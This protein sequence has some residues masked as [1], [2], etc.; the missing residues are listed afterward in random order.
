[1]ADIFHTFI[2]KATPGKIFENITTAEGLDKWWTKSSK[3]T[4]EIGALYTLHFGSE[5]NWQAIVT[6]LI[7]DNEFE[8]QITHAYDDWMNTKVGFILKP[9]NEV[10]S[11]E[12][13]HTGWQRCNEHYKISTYCWAMYLR[14]LK[15]YTEHGE[16]VDY[17]NRL[18]V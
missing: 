17:E 12:F 11:V 7:E 6:K 5:Y 3:G 1:M 15:R 14:L 8:L 10:T 16:Q 13:Y 18:D 2:I 4:S 9:V